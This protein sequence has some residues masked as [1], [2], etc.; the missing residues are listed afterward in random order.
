MQQPHYGKASQHKVTMQF[1]MFIAPL[2]LGEVNPSLGINISWI[3]ELYLKRHMFDTQVSP[4]LRKKASFLR[5][6]WKSTCSFL[7]KLGRARSPEGIFSPRCFT[8]AYRRF[9]LGAG[10]PLESFKCWPSTVQ[11]IHCSGKYSVRVAGE[12]KAFACI[13]S[14]LAA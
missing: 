11:L 4:E 2:N 10:I 9:L 14:K 3:D 1:S 5:L 6:G 7:K 13:E 8:D 12:N